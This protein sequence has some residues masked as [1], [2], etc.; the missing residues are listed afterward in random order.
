M[1]LNITFSWLLF[2]FHFHY[3]FF[4][5]FFFFCIKRKERKIYFP[6]DVNGVYILGE[7]IPQYMPQL[8]CFILIK[9]LTSFSVLCVLFL[10][11]L[12]ALCRRYIYSESHETQMRSGVLIGGPKNIFI[13]CCLL[14]DFSCYP[15]AAYLNF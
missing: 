1:F 14:V 11:E 9:S 4:L 12:L 6:L 7:V 5:F 8:L 13:L 15:E 3:F 2:P 10:F